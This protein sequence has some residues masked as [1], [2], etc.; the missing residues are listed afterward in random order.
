VC[1][2]S[3]ARSTNGTGFLT[4]TDWLYKTIPELHVEHGAW[5]AG[6]HGLYVGC[7]HG[8]RHN[9]RNPGVQND[10]VAFFEDTTRE[11]K[12]LAF[13]GSIDVDL[14]PKVLTLTAG[15]RHYHFD[16]YFKGSVSSS[17]GCFEAGA[18]AGGCIA[19]ANNLD[20]RNLT[21]TESGFKSRANLTWHA[22]PDIMAYLTWSH[23]FRPGGFNR[24]NSCHIKGPDG[25]NQFCLPQTYKSD[26]LT[27]YEFGWKTEFLNQPPAVERRPLP[28]KLGQRAG[29]LLRSRRDRQPDLRHQRTELPGSG[30]RDFGCGPG[31]AGADTAGCGI[32]EPE[33]TDQLPVL[34]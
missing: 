27:N 1:A 28:G 22:T 8:P 2:A 3:P 33:R 29:R 4:K 34:H 21:S 13:F 23:G 20:K 31:R 11:V 7:R 5:N 9:G 12:Q 6:E 24:T 30:H 10:N 14:I 26:N 32:L 17:F 16:E 18:P 15:T 19:G 25:L